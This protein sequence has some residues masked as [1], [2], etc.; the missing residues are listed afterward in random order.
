MCEFHCKMIKEQK[1]SVRLSEQ[2]C[3]QF[4]GH[5]KGKL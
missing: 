1:G 5:S 2:V 4:L 3:G